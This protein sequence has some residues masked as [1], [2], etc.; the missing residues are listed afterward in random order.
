MRLVSCKGQTEWE[1]KRNK[2]TIVSCYGCGRRVKLSKVCAD[3]DGK[4]F[5]AYYCTE[6]VKKKGGRSCQD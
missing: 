4:S 2:E 1:R 6:C 3:L 5:K